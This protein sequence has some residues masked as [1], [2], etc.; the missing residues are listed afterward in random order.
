MKPSM[1]RKTVLLVNAA[2][3]TL[4]LLLMTAGALLADQA[5]LASS[6]RNL[7]ESAHLA[8]ALITLDSSKDI[9][10]HRLSN[11]GS[12]RLTLIAAD[13]TVLSDS[14]SDPASMGNH[15][16]RPEVVGALQG[17]SS[18]DVRISAT[19][20]MRTLYA[21][22]PLVLYKSSAE[23]VL[24][25]AM[26]LPS[27]FARL[28]GLA[29][30]PPIFLLLVILFSVG[31]SALIQQSVTIPI[32]KLTE[33]AERYSNSESF[34][35]IKLK[36]IPR[37]LLPINSA[38]DTMAKNILNRSLENRRMRSRY[39]A[40]LES[41]SE[42][43]IASDE[44]LRIQE[45]NK[46]AAELFGINEAK[47]TQCIG[48]SVLKGLRNSL[49]NEIFE[50]CSHEK[51]LIIR[52]IPFF[53]ENGER[54]YDVHASPFEDEE[55]QGIV[56]IV[57]DVTEIRRLERIRK[58]FVTNVSHEI[59]T[60]VQVIKGYTEIMSDRLAHT[61]PA[62]ADSDLFSQLREQSGIIH[63]SALRM[64]EIIKDL[65]L[66]SRLERDPGNWI[67]KEPCRIQPILELA[68]TA[69][70]N[71]AREK[72]MPILIACPEE[73]EAEVNSGLLEQALTNLVGNALQYSF[74]GT[75]IEVSASTKD[76]KLIISVRDHGAGIPAKDLD[77]IF[78]RFYRVDKSR[79]RSTGGT[80]L[81]LAIVKH[82][83]TAH[84]GTVSVESAV[85]QG[86]VFTISLPAGN[87]RNL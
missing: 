84:G 52:E 23:S 57:S 81:G 86:T 85:G 58:D 35:E 39:E 67:I 3:L 49:L 71:Q 74:S 75:A 73:L 4:T 38:L 37:E 5:Y 29:W 64:E 45:V 55:T 12:I 8:S 41:A 33:K 26:P 15:A 63:H 18:W 60:P 56:A 25:L 83:A 77:H 34:S 7:L 61:E 79:N 42:G 40:I 36:N 11:S 80:G 17:K 82:I 30:I 31:T 28:S 22:V 46:A 50:T 27:F 76:N 87:M 66:L 47:R 1:F 53:S 20:G 14:S 78:E 21:A 44:S 54:H 10:L 16:S 43:I 70:E 2:I 51:R 6:A 13:G 48:Q 32:L 19:T 65:L 9:D 24:R 68:K 69:L 72:N 59:R 62:S